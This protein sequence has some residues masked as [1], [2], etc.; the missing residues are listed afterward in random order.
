MW[1]KSSIALVKEDGESKMVSQFMMELWGLKIV[2]SEDLSN[3][4]HF[5]PKIKG[6]WIGQPVIEKN[7][8][9]RMQ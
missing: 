5:N 1:T 4:L 2:D 7:T 6:D 9:Y 3:I 8:C